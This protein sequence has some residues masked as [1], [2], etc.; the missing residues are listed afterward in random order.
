MKTNPKEI[1]DFFNAQ[2]KVNQ[3]KENLWIYEI[4]P[5]DAIVTIKEAEEKGLFCIR[6]MVPISN[7]DGYGKWFAVPRKQF[8][9]RNEFDEFAE[10]ILYR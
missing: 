6:E 8:S 9:T 1:K 5:D 7:W 10:K 3:A 2:A 4:Y